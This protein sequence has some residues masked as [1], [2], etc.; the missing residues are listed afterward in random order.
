M[1]LNWGTGLTIF[2]VIFCLGIFVFMY[3][4]F[5]ND[6][7]L[8][9]EDYYPKELNYQ[10]QIDQMENVQKLG[11]QVQIEKS[12]NFI[13]LKFPASQSE[14]SIQGQILIYR[15]SNEKLDLTYRIKLDSNNMQQISTDVLVPGKYLFKIAWAYQGIAYYQELTF[16]Y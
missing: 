9:E 5:N 4:A 3:V 13:S 8:V 16:I 6:I 15:P 12:D 7:E 2:I 1:K 10:S 11:E 14:D